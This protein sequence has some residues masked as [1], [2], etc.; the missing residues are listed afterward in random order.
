M[1]LSEHTFDTGIVRLNYAEVPSP[2]TPLVLL[3]GGNARW[4]SFEAMLPGLAAQWHVYA[5]DFRGHGKSHW[6]TGSYRLQDY[7]DDTIAF[8]QQQ[9]REPACLFGHSL[10]GIVALMVAAQFPNGVRAVAVGDAPLSSRTWHDVLHQQEERLLA[11]PGLCGGQVPFDQ[12]VE[13]IKDTP[14]EVSGREESV[15]MREVMGED[16]P[17]YAWLAANLYQSDPDVLTALNERFD[18]TA[19]GYEMDIV[20]PQVG[21]PVL[22]LQADPVAGGLVTDAEVVQ[23]LA[24]LDQPVHVRLEGVSH[25]LHHVHPELVGTAIKRFFQ[26]R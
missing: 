2:A 3:H 15:A 11:W 12:L 25:A 22:L 6:A 16:A 10:G 17:A 19:A 21:C 9:V 18:A 4:Q 20:L 1:E 24:L 7:T 13:A 14:I 26:F 8:L 23:A 5:P